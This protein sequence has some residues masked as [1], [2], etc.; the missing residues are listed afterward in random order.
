[1]FA[2]SFFILALVAL[3]SAVPAKRTPAQVITKCTVPNTVA[4]TFDDG[5]YKNMQKIVDQ[6]TAAGAVGTFFFN[7][8]NRDCI[9]NKESV[10]RA[11]YA[12]SKGHQVASH[13]WS[14]PHMP[15][16]DRDQMVSQCSRIDD[17]LKKILG[18]VPAFARPPYGE[19]NDLFRQ[20]AQ[21]RGQRLVNWDFDSGDSVGKTAAESRQMYDDVVE[22]HPDTLLALNHEVYPWLSA[23][24]WSRISSKALLLP[25][26]YAFGSSAKTEH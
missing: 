6:L 21:E 15:D 23:W 7:G 17:A 20:V 12:F 1:M 26:M 8:D 13:T 2:A 5:P 19:Y 14:H 18:V 3:A 4:L 10:Q 25:A 16:L 22:D 11:Q 24:A 9:Y